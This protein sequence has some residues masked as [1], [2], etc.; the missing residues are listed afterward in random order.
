MRD[1]TAMVR[2]KV[3][4]ARSKIGYL[5]VEQ[6]EE[7]LPLEQTDTTPQNPASET[8]H[9]RMHLFAQ[10]L[11]RR[12]IEA[13]SA[14]DLK[15]AAAGGQISA[16]A[17]SVSMA[18]IAADR[19]EDE[20]LAMQQEGENAGEEGLIEVNGWHREPQ[21]ADDIQNGGKSLG[22]AADTSVKSPSQLAMQVDQMRKEEL[23]QLLQKLQM[24]NM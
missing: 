17:K 12:Q 6:V 21:L 23:D 9:Q 13:Q 8:I 2:N 14:G 4:R 15:T 20:S 24:E 5:P 19:A 10:R 3:R 18:A 11:E 16:G 1:F 7:G 22:K